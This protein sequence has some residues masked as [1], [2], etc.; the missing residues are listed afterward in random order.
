MLSFS[1]ICCCSSFLCVQKYLQRTPSR[2]CCEWNASSRIRLELSL[3][4]VSMFYCLTASSDI[5][6]IA[7]SYFGYL[8]YNVLLFRGIIRNRCYDETGAPHKSWSYS[9][10]CWRTYCCLYDAYSCLIFVKMSLELVWHSNILIFWVCFCVVKWDAWG[11]HASM[12]IGW[13]C[14]NSL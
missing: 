10:L 7:I 12:N 11:A 3:I 5:S 4:K 13:W 9:L 1:C 14:F 8:M 2:I 6:S